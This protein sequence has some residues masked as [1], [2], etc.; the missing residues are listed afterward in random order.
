MR[1]NSEADL[2]DTNGHTKELHPNSNPY[3]TQAARAIR[4]TWRQAPP[5]AQRAH[6]ES[7][8]HYDPE[9]AYDVRHEYE[10]DWTTNPDHP[11]AGIEFAE[12][13]ADGVLE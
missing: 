4:A 5:E 3:M 10:Y 12:C 1:C 13:D 6:L 2:G 11:V 7:L 8:V 9:H